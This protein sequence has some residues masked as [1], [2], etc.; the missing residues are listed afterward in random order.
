MSVT[1]PSL[2]HEFKPEVA[3]ASTDAK[4]QPWQ[5]VAMSDE[6]QIAGA[7]LKAL[8]EAKGWSQE[9]LAQESG[10][11]DKTLMSKMERGLI[12]LNDIKLRRLSQALGCTPGD[13]LADESYEPAPPHKDEDEALFNEARQVMSDT[14]L[15]DVRRYLRMRIEIARARQS[16]PPSRKS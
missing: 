5:L 14:E 11:G 8:R 2:Q 1:L 16:S 9:K 3:K 13:L 10:L 15:D 12:R 7:R 4:L 6:Q